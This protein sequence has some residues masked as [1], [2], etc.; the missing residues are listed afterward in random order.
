MYKGKIIT[1]PINEA[2]NEAIKLEQIDEKSNRSFTVSVE[3]MNSTKSGTIGYLKVGE[4][5]SN[6][7]DTDH[8]IPSKDLNKLYARL[9]KL[10]EDEVKKF[11]KSH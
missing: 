2:Y 10:C 7:L 9:L 11:N 4:P 3:I 6:Q 1:D 5:N 8:E